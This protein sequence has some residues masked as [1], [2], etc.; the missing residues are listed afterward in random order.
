MK[1]AKKFDIVVYGASG[2]TGRLVAEYL[3]SRPSD[4]GDLKW[5]MAG[6]SLEER[7]SEVREQI[8]P[9]R[10]PDIPSIKA[11]ARHPA[12]LDA[13]LGK[14]R[15]VLTTVGPYQLYGYG[16]VAACAASGNRLP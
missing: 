4:G 3:A 15:A 12:S 2:F 9:A 16:L 7:L 6:R 11:D 13:M 10:G 5:A 14:T 8:G 1:S